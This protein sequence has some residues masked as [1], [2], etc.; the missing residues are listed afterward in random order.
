MIDTLI[1]SKTRIK[2][3]IKFFLNGNASAYLRGLEAELGESTNS[4]RLELNRLEHAGMITSRFV[5]NKKIF[6]ANQSHPLFSDIHNILVKYIGL[7]SIIENVIKRL[8]SVEKVYLTGG[9]A[10]GKNDE[11]IDLIIIGDVDQD[12][13]SLLCV[14][15]ET[16]I[17]RKIRYVIQNEIEFLGF[18]GENQFEP[19][20]IWSENVE[21][22]VQ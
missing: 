20:L 3:L 11:I 13:L 15:A 19:L 12:Y 17:K 8:G 22:W 7:D 2:L 9:L 18:Q 5:G 14:K 4:I 10:Q 16:L 1:S 21:G 6:K